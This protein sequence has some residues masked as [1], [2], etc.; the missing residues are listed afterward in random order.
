MRT[1]PI[2]SGPSLGVLRGRIYAPNLFAVTGFCAG[3]YGGPVPSGQTSSPSRSRPLRDEGGVARGPSPARSGDCLPGPIR[4]GQSA[5]TAVESHDLDCESCGR[6]WPEGWF[7][8]VETAKGGTL[9]V[10]ARCAWAF[11]GGR[12][13]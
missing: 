5:G 7:E 4:S 8:R 6:D 2:A 1:A 3:T 12:A 13:R 10:C 11:S 9:E